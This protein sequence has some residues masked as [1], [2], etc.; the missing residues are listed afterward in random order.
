MT[1]SVVHGICF[2]GIGTPWRA[3]ELGEERYWITADAFHAILD[4]IAEAPGIRISFDDGNA[5]DLDIGL[6]AL[7]ERKLVGSFFVIAGRLGSRGSL[8]ADGLR[9][10]RRHGMM[11][12]T[13][14][15]DHRP[16]RNL[17]PRDKQ[18]ELIE[19]RHR[20]ADVVGSPVNEVALPMGSYDR[21]LLSDL[22]HLGYT[23]VHT[24]DRRT[25]R[26]GAWLQPRFSVLAEDTVE[27]VERYGLVAPTPMARAWLAAKGRLKHVR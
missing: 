2:H 6:P 11:I 25:A 16:W 14:G 27:T 15:M 4:A 12:G 18:R 5:S 23:A 19:A 9:E 8:D 21:R 22:K 7:L 24:S 17:A 20:I 13:H 10:L 26:D 1:G 3:L